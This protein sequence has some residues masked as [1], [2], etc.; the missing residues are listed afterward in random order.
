MGISYPLL[1]DLRA[2]LQQVVDPQ[3][4]GQVVNAGYVLAVCS[5]RMRQAQLE[6]CHIQSDVLQR[7]C[8]ICEGIC[9]VSYPIYTQLSQLSKHKTCNAMAL[10]SQKTTWASHLRPTRSVPQT[11]SCTRPSTCPSLGIFFSFFFQHT[12]NSN[13]GLCMTLPSVEVQLA[14]VTM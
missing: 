6:W 11:Q 2:Q 5:G 4:P 13:W 1:I 14:T 12:V 8:W 3:M 10:P 9:R 7:T